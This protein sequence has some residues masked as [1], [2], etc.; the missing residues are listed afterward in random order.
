VLTCASNTWKCIKGGSGSFS[1]KFVIH[2]GPSSSFPATTINL[3]GERASSP[4]KLVIIIYYHYYYITQNIAETLYK[5]YIHTYIQRV[6]SHIKGRATSP[7][8]RDS[9]RDGP[10]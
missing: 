9:R 8:T 3:C 1:Q 5:K 10:T 7:V 6:I 2:R 4:S